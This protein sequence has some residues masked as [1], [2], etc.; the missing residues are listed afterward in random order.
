[1]DSG[2][3]AFP[4]DIE[5]LKAALAAARDAR[6]AA[7][8][9]AAHAEAEL[10]VARAKTSDDQALI[11]H[12]QLRIEKLTRQLYGPR[13]ER[14]SRLL[15]QIELQFEELESLATEDEITAE[16]AVA[17]TTVAAFTRKRRRASRSPNIC[18]ASGLSCRDRPLVCAVAAGGCASWGRTSLRRWT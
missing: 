4:N 18:R 6:I 5:E 9:K 12:Q 8:A 10:A 16:I 2:R 1:M 3:E 11:A 14:A 15:D 7:V 13:S 17:K